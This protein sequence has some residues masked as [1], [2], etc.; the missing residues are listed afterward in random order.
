MVQQRGTLTE[1]AATSWTTK[2]LLFMYLFMTGEGLT[3]IKSTA[4]STAGKWSRT[5]VD[6]TMLKQVSLFFKSFS[7]I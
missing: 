2:R 4:T 5:R 3:P 6:Y 1:T 7:T